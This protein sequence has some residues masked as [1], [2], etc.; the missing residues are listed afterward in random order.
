MN[1]TTSSSLIS[2]WMS[3]ERTHGPKLQA[4]AGRLKTAFGPRN[5]ITA[6]TLSIAVLFT[7]I[8][9][10]SWTHMPGEESSVYGATTFN[11]KVNVYTVD[12]DRLAGAGGASSGPP[13]ADS[14]VSAKNDHALAHQEPGDVFLASSALDHSSSFEDDGMQAVGHFLPTTDLAA[15]A[16]AVPLPLPITGAIAGEW[17]AALG[18]E[19]LTPSLSTVWREGECQKFAVFFFGNGHRLLKPSL[20][21]PYTYTCRH[22]RVV[23][24]FALKHILYVL[25]RM[26]A[27]CFYSMIARM[28]ASTRTH[29]RYTHNTRTYN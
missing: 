26:C 22:V 4:T 10:R 24:N 14:I 25:F 2:E 1:M 27:D 8:L 29:A 5:L 11:V 13:T 28:S 12:G 18:P 16:A 9:G 21:I 19:P 7:I 23:F 3:R 6:G 20:R 17:D 15:A